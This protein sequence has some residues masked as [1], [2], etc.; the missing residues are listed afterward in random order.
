VRK[1]ILVGAIVLML[2]IMLIPALA[3]ARII[4][5]PSPS[6]IFSEQ[7]IDFHDSGLHIYGGVVAYETNS[8]G[9]SSRELKLSVLIWT[10][11]IQEVVI[12]VSLSPSEFDHPDTTDFLCKAYREEGIYDPSWTCTVTMK[13]Q[14][15]PRPLFGRTCFG[16]RADAGPHGDVRDIEFHYMTYPEIDHNEDLSAVVRNVIMYGSWFGLP[17]PGVISPLPPT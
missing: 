3:G 2:A 6:R 4:T 7:S 1:L 10:A 12:S 16:V 17:A 8:S 9:A 5:E 13:E 15:S 14:G 11:G